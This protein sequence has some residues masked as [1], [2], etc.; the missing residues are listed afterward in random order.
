MSVSRYDLWYEFVKV[1]WLGGGSSTP[2][3][4]AKRS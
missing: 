1:H 4:R 2:T 3:S